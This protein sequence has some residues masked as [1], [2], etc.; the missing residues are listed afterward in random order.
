GAG[1]GTRL[2][3][4]VAPS[5]PWR[6]CSGSLVGLRLLGEEAEKLADL[7]LAGERVR[8]RKVWL[9]RV[10]VAPAVSLAGEVARCLELGDDAVGGALGDP[11]PLADLPQGQPGLIRDAEQQLTVVGQERP[12]R[13]GSWHRH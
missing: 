3:R 9:D 2:P 4:A 10:A 8:E 11:D 12:F 5:G 7:P 13:R 6:S 1:G